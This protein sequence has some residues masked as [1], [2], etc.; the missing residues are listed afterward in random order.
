MNWEI[1]QNIFFS[2]MSDRNEVTYYDTAK[3]I[4]I[5]YMDQY[6][7]PLSQNSMEAFNLCMERASRNEPADHINPNVHKQIPILKT[8]D[9]VVSI[10]EVIS[11]NQE[12]NNLRQSFDKT[13]NS[14]QINNNNFLNTNLSSNMFQSFLDSLAQE[15]IRNKLGDQNT[16]NLL[17]KETAETL[18]N[19]FVSGK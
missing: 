17:Y 5:A 10:K 1:T 19:K 15:V 2:M 16:I 12:F 8:S 11:T 13:V 18:A 7:V 6:L 14:F 3:G 9:F 4:V